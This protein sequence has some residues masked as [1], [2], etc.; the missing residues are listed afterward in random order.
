MAR[1][2][3]NDHKKVVTVVAQLNGELG[4]QMHKIA[5]AVCVQRHIER[6]LHLPTELKLKA[7]DSPKWERAMKWMKEAFPSTRPLDFRAGNTPLFDR[8]Q[9][10]QEAWIRQLVDSQKVNLTGIGNPKIMNRM[11]SSGWQPTQEVLRLLNRTWHLD[12][13][14]APGGSTEFSIPHIYSDTFT[15]RYCFESML[16]EIRDFFKIDEYRICKQKPTPEESVLHLRN[17][18]VEMGDA[19]LELG[20]EE[21]NPEKTATEIFANYTPGDKVA[22]VSRYEQNTDKYIQA[23]KEIRGIDA[24]YIKGQTGNQDFCFLL[25]SQQEIIGQR[26]STFATWAG[27]LGRPKKLRLYSVDSKYTRAKKKAFYKARWDHKELKHRIVYENYK[28]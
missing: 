13:P 24:R 25:K 20:F 19:G 10:I 28:A 6:K 3:S 27:L 15:S 22:I 8:V 14:V 4:N 21:L 16:D 7:Q 12:R 18:L 1:F 2:Q 11:K 17:F 23:L 26:I 5:N 9:Q